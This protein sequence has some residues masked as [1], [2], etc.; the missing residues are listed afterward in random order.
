MYSFLVYDCTTSA[1]RIAPLPLVGLRLFR[2]SESVERQLVHFSNQFIW[3]KVSRQVAELFLILK[4]YDVKPVRL[5][6]IAQAL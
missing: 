4:N 2:K 6:L 5:L 1:C 3:L